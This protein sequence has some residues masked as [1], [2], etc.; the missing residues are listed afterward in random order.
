MPPLIAAAMHSRSRLL[1]ATRCW[2]CSGPHEGPTTIYIAAV[3]KLLLR[4]P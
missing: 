2:A 3:M 4:A 1:T